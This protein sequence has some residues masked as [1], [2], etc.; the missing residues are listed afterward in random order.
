MQDFDTESSS[1]QLDQRL[2]N[3]RGSSVLFQGDFEQTSK[4]RRVD[5]ERH[6]RTPETPPFPS[7]SA[8]AQPRQA[9]S[10][11]ASENGTQLMRSQ[12]NYLHE[13]RLYA[14]AFVGETIYQPHLQHHEIPDTAQQ[15]VHDS[16]GDPKSPHT[17]LL[18]SIFAGAPTD[19]KVCTYV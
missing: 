16:L 5:Q 14:R 3:E 17:S 6:L 1:T 9:R 13:R 12:A 2:Q 7:P 15:A 11:S 18:A 8:A 19:L 4:R 10:D